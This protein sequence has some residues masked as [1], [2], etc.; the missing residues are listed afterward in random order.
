MLVKDTALADIYSAIT[1]GKKEVFE[2]VVAATDTLGNEVSSRFLVDLVHDIAS[3]TEDCDN[4][5]DDNTNGAIDCGDTQ[6]AQAVSCLESKGPG[7]EIC[8]N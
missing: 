6:C 2:I 7:D 1:P 4:G 8:K 5:V 3:T